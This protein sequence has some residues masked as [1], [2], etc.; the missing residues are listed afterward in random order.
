M[1]YNDENSI[2]M[3][4]CKM[5][6]YFSGTG[7]SKWVAEQLSLSLGDRTAD[8][9]RT[10]VHDH[11]FVPGERVGIVF[12]IFAWNVPEIVRDFVRELHPGSAYTFAVCTCGES[13]GHAITELCD[14]IP[15]SSAYSVIM[16]DN[17]IIGDYEP[18]T[19]EQIH[20]KLLA[21]IQR[22]ANIARRI[23][24][25]RR[26]L[27]VHLGKDAHSRTYEIS[28]L[29]NRTMRFT[30]LFYTTSGRCS[31]CGLCAELCPVR[32]IT[33]IDGGPLWVRP[34]CEMCLGC[35]NRCPKQAIEYGDKTQG[36]PR[37]I[38]PAV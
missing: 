13:A 21:A 32:A 25:G 31:C 35:I 1:Y 27:D 7:N 12:P 16:P 34:V 17:Y 9:A 36:K 37:Y 14:L 5:I 29:F 30:D 8:I 3:G 6:F 38:F 19:P 15:L 23:A 26:E 4:D 22:V 28:P 11:S 24:D 33:L 10:G 20:Q 2:E 18:E